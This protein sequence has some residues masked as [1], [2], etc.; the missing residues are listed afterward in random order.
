[1]PELPGLAGG[2]GE[3]VHTTLT[4]APPERFVADQTQPSP[5]G[6]NTTST[7]GATATVQLVA[8]NGSPIIGTADLTPGTALADTFAVEADGQLTPHYTGTTEMQWDEQRTRLAPDGAIHVV[9][10][11]GQVWSA[12]ECRRLAA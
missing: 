11:D 8:P 7:T 5:R 10:Q 6:T 9:A 1:M 3:R 4:P 12:A 2:A